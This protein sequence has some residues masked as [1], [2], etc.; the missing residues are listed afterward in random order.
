MRRTSVDVARDSAYCGNALTHM[1][2]R[3]CISEI[4]SYARPYNFLEHLG[5]PLRTR[6][7]KARSAGSSTPDGT[8]NAPFPIEVVSNVAPTISP[9]MSRPL[10]TVLQGVSQMLQKRLILSL[11]KA[12]VGIQ[13]HRKS[14]SDPFSRT[15]PLRSSERVHRPIS[16][17]RSRLLYR[18]AQR[19]PY[20]LETARSSSRLMMIRQ[21]SGSHI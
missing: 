15:G 7:P 4:V 10:R 20:T 21:R 18:G 8:R 6:I 19:N 12:H 2:A 17:S 1:K 5:E 14:G 9:L 13:C 11:G 16:H 3:G